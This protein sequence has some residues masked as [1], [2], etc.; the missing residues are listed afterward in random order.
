MAFLN[1]KHKTN[2][3]SYHSYVASILDFASEIYGCCKDKAAD[4]IH[5]HALHFI[6]GVHKFCSLQAVSED[7]VCWL[8]VRKGVILFL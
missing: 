6:L 7:D 2:Y 4:K 8:G 3:H 5:N 1:M